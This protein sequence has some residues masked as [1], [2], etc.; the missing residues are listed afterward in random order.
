MICRISFSSPTLLLRL[1]KQNKQRLINEDSNTIKKYERQRDIF[2][3]SSMLS[4]PLNTQTSFIEH[5]CAVE[6]N[7]IP[8]WLFQWILIF[9]LRYHSMRSFTNGTCITSLLGSH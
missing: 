2:V 3:T 8:T 7:R 5:Q 1:R 9:R 6:I 4:N